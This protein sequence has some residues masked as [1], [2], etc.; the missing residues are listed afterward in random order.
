MLDDQKIQEL[1]GQA[2]ASA[3]EAATRDQTFMAQLAKG[4][5]D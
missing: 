2:M 1:L 5:I 4:R 3:I